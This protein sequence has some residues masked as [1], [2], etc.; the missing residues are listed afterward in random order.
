MQDIALFTFY[1]IL[2]FQNNSKI[3]TKLTLSLIKL[4]FVVIERSYLN[5]LETFS[6]FSN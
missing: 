6:K 4:H 2:R 5:Y 3:F 1:N